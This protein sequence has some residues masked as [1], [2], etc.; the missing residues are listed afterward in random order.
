MFLPAWILGVVMAIV[1]FIILLS[2]KE[3]DFLL[4]NVGSQKN[5]AMRLIAIIMVIMGLVLLFL[6]N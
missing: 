1:G 2:G 4:A 3:P 6:S 5:A